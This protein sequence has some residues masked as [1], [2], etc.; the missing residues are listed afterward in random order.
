MEDY[1]YTTISEAEVFANS[2][3]N[4]PNYIHYQETG[5]IN[6]IMIACAI[7]DNP[8]EFKDFNDVIS[9]ILDLFDDDYE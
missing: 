8:L 1:S 4:D 7:E 6:D 3:E 9:E 2:S 5:K